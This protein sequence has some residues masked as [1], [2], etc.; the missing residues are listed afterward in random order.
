MPECCR[1][2]VSLL[3]FPEG[4]RQFCLQPSESKQ[5]NLC[6]S[7]LPRPYLPLCSWG[8]SQIHRLIVGSWCICS[9]RMHGTCV[10]KQ[11][12]TPDLLWRNSPHK[13]NK[14][15]LLHHRS[16]GLGP[17]QEELGWLQLPLSLDGPHSQEIA[18]ELWLVRTFG[19][20]RSPARLCWVPVA[21]VANTPLVLPW[22]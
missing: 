9:S 13:S 20:R 12:C 5:M 3:L 4:F 21:A 17:D 8:S 19:L 1:S 11:F 18:E 2:G 15:P 6:N 22:H 16:M 14:H 10:G 7:K